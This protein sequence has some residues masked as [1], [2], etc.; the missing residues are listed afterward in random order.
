MTGQ[1][2]TAQ[3]CCCAHAMHSLCGWR[4]RDGAQSAH[5]EGDRV[6]EVAEALRVPAAGVQRCL[7]F[8]TCGLG[9]VLSRRSWYDASAMLLGGGCPTGNRMQGSSSSWFRLC[10]AEQGGDSLSPAVL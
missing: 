7:S 8:T 6:T 1:G 5:P 10:V 3:S 4:V 2:A 9:S